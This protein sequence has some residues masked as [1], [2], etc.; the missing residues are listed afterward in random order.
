MRRGELAMNLMVVLG[1]ALVGL[2]TVLCINSP[3]V[4]GILL[5]CALGLLMFVLNR[6]SQPR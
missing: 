4:A 1:P 2:L 3:A 5:C 6:A